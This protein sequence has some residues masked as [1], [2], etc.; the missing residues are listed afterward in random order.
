MKLKYQ[1]AVAGMGVLLIVVP[2]LLRRRAPQF[3]KDF[4]SATTAPL[5]LAIFRIVFFIIILRYF[6]VDVIAWFGSLP[7]E[8][9]VP[10]PGLHT[11]LRY[12]PMSESLAWGAAVGMMVFAVASML[13]LFTRVSIILC[14]ILSLYALGLPQFFGK[15]N[16]YHHLVWFMAILAVS[17]C[18]DVLSI[19]SIRKA[20]KRADHGVIEPPGPSQVY[21]LPLRFVWIL[22]GVIYFSAG[23]WKVWTGGYKWAWSDNPKI[24]MYNKW[25]ELSGW[26][27]FFRIDHYP[28]LYKMSAVF[29]I[30]F[31]LSFIFI[32]FFPAIRYLAP[33]GGLIFHHSTNL[34]MRILFSE[35]WYCYVAFP[36]W[37]RV[38]R[39]VGR[40][41]FRRDMYILYDGNCRLCR[42]TVGSF[43]MFDILERVVYLNS[44]DPQAL[45]E[46]DLLWLDS[47]SLMHDM[48]SVVGREVWTGFQSYRAW[49][50]RIP[51]LWPILPLLYL[52]PITTLGKRIY[53]HVADSRSCSVKNRIRLTNREET[54]Q[55]KAKII[56]AA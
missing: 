7:R 53:R 25:M 40:K 3:I 6:S 52:W 18:A 44:L 31:E 38:F 54:S 26:R 14:F 8:L 47:Q 30:L 15:I 50:S 49:I 13:G 5:N 37:R 17:P 39:Y 16:H 22:L 36:D 27:P 48:H 35:L 51:P 45:R 43:R 1:I 42:R 32:I 12:L 19:D 33:V 41:L 46:H 29:T 34:F 11:V 2:L 9:Q 20:W 4:F 24:L 56:I 21:A 55:R 28:L 23:I 10:P